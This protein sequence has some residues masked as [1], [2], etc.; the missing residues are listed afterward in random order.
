MSHVLSLLYGHFSKSNSLNEICD[1]LRLHEADLSRIRGVTAPKRNTFSNANRT[2]N[3]E[4]AEALY[5]QILKSLQTACPSFGQGSKYGGFI[6]RI[7]RDIFAIDSTTLKLTMNCFDWARHRRKKAAAKTHMR[8]N[9]GNMLPCVAVVEDAAHHD[10][11]RGDAL[12][13]SLKDG[14][15]LLADRAYVKFDFLNA[16]SQQG[17]FFVLREKKNMKY[18][19]LKNNDHKDPTIISDETITLSL[20]GSKNKYPENIRR[21]TA[22]VKVNGKDV[23]MSFVTNNFKWSPRTIAELYKA[24]WIIE[25]FFKEIK[26]TLQLSDFIG[27]NENAVKWQVWIGLLAHLLIRFAKH[28]SKWKLS[29]SRLAGTIRSALWMRIDLL[30]TLIIYGT[31]DPPKRPVVFAQQLYFKGFE[32]YTSN[33]MGQPLSKSPA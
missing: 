33:T 23:Q 10:S 6:S 20:A 15:I 26:Q 22:I 17:V 24:R 12:C 21:V 19:V 25:V 8:I 5:W 1:A 31:A 30:E 2:R 3:P 14:D 11:T 9:I 28:Q 7:K 32:A 13:A 29:F 4:I 27:Y 16:L 18:T